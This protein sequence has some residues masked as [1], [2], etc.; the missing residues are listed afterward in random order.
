M[1]S[2]YVARQ[3]I[4]ELGKGLY[5]YEL[6]YRRDA[7]IERADGEDGY[8][9]A[10]VI[11]GALLGIGLRAISGGGVAF[12]NFSRGQ[13]LARSWELFDAGGVVIE[14]LENVE[15][16]EDT[17]AA[18]QHM[19][20]A[21]YRLALDDYV[22]DER[23]LPL[24]ELASI[25]KIDVL[26]RP[27]AEL[28]LVAQQLAPF[29][30]R[31]LAERVETATVRDVCAD[32][33]YELFQGYL[34]SRPETLTKTDVSA[35]QLAIM[36]LLNLLQD[37]NTPDTVLDAAF[38]SDVAL[39]YKLLRIVNA[40]SLGGRGI[41]S[42]PHAVRMVGRETLHRWLAVILVA[43]LG[44]KGDVTHE[45]ALTAIT[46]ARM[47][48]LLAS[49]AGNDNRGA[50]SAFIV[51]LLSLLDVLLEVPMEKILGR[52]EL[53]DEVRGALLGRG[54]P[55]GTPLQLVEAYERADWSTTRGMASDNAVSDEIL[56][57]MYMDALQWAAQRLTA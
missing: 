4:F 49:N 24:L 11:A 12:V 28:E 10:D 32:F 56:P 35:S 42:I 2:I 34:F 25:V 47:C 54:G 1:S 37:P 45:I 33:G 26:N 9:S 36:R 7:S 14:L 51:G 39:C 17:V 41:T 29:G 53:S 20:Q 27:I 46:R 15:C 5:G 30:V 16:D 40:A 48:E 52:L 21:G 18:C 38:Q 55:F 3:P 57:T 8:M 31:L 13:L 50:G 43:S 44:R 22:Y 6:L 23:T 19:V